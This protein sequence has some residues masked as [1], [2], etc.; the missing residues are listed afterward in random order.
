MDSTVS[1]CVTLKLLFDLVITHSHS[2]I[3]D[4]KYPILSLLNKYRSD[5]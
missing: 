5:L 4:P 1:P 2:L 3:V